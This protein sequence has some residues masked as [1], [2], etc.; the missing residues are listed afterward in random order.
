MVQAVVEVV[1]MVIAAM[2]QAVVAATVGGG[3]SS[4]VGGSGVSYNSRGGISCSM[5]YS[6]S[7]VNH[8]HSMRC[9]S[10]GNRDCEVRCK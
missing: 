9:C 3:G 8:K 1:I 7:N 5:G 2:R 6:I 10:R 4:G